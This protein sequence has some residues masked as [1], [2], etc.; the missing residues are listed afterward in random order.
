MAAPPLKN[1]RT[2]IEV[3]ISARNATLASSASY[4]TPLVLHVEEI[5]PDTFSLPEPGVTVHYGIQRADTTR[6]RG[7]ESEERT[8]LDRIATSVWLFF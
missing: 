6:K 1:I 2:K 8:R 7:V 3:D 5:T 4:K